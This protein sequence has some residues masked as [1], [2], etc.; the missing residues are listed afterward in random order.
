[1]TENSTVVGNDPGPPTPPAVVIDNWNDETYDDTSITH[2]TVAETTKTWLTRLVFPL[3]PRAPTAKLLTRINSLISQAALS[4]NT[5]IIPTDHAKDRFIVTGPF[6]NEQVLSNCFVHKTT[7]THIVG[8]LKIR[9]PV[10][11]SFTQW[12]RDNGSLLQHMQINKIYWTTTSLNSLDTR[13]PIFL[14]D[15]PSTGIDLQQLHHQITV[16]C[17]IECPFA[18][19]ASIV[20]E[21]PV[22][23]PC[24]V[25]ECD[26]TDVQKVTTKM[27]MGLIKPIC[28]KLW[29]SHPI[30]RAKPMT[31]SAGVPFYP[32]CTKICRLEALTRQRELMAK[33]I[34][35]AFINVANIDTPFDFNNEKLTLRDIIYD[36]L[37]VKGTRPVHGI[38]ETAQGRILISMDKTKATD[39]LAKL[40][41]LFT[42]M[43]QM[44]PLLQDITGYADRPRRPNDPTLV[45]P[46]ASAYIAKLTQ[47]A[48]TTIDKAT[49]NKPIRGSS[50]GMESSQQNGRPKHS[51]CW[52][53]PPPT[54]Y[55]MNAPHQ[56]GLPLQKSKAIPDLLLTPIDDSMMHIHDASITEENMHDAASIYDP[57]APTPPVLPQTTRDDQHSIIDVDDEETWNPSRGLSSIAIAAERNKLMEM[58]YKNKELSEPATPSACGLK[59]IIDQCKLMES[60]LL[61]Q[62]HDGIKAVGEDLHVNLHA[63]TA[64]KQDLSFLMTRQQELV[65]AQSQLSQSQSE[66]KQDMQRLLRGLTQITD[67]LSHGGVPSTLDI[68]P[69]VTSSINYLTTIVQEDKSNTTEKLESIATALSSMDTNHDDKIGSM[70]STL[71]RIG[72]NQD[73]LMSAITNMHAT[74]TSTLADMRHQ[75]NIT[76]TTSGDM[77]PLG[78]KQAVINSITDLHVMVHDDRRQTSEILTSITSQ[79]ALMNTN[80]QELLASIVSNQ[81]D[82]SNSMSS[83]LVQLRTNQ[84]DLTSAM[85]QMS[86]HISSAL[87]NMGNNLMIAANNTSTQQSQALCAFMQTITDDRKHS[88]DMITRANGSNEDIRAAIHH[89]STSTTTLVKTQQELLTITNNKTHGANCSSPLR[90]LQ[91]TPIRQTKKRAKS[92]HRHHTWTQQILNVVSVP[93][94]HQFT[95][96]TSPPRT[97]LGTSDLVTPPAFDIP[98]LQ[99]PPLPA[100]LPSPSPLQLEGP[101]MVVE[102]L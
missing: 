84:D 48:A 32:T 93:N 85:T 100:S 95:F 63:T 37:Q 78:D 56:Q 47:S 102:E 8:L 9:L 83:T 5:C 20:T 101:G 62:F 58:L 14:Y 60:D 92:A 82:L 40:E 75:M 39:T 36:K 53:S 77:D 70:S 19:R 3:A 99:L 67:T 91:S 51:N 57:Y 29:T 66:M 23:A 10:D 88:M 28:N 44:G 69:G 6:K 11:L 59:A 76:T 87:T 90:I 22:T 81:R 50:Q 7:R 42:T 97:T 46:Q 16:Q 4:K 27:F 24:I 2:N 26:A 41:L 25:V 31:L 13:T 33:Q 35:F 64:L 96:G 45:H 34:R 30:S 54:I 68:S 52:T 61:H 15:I 79:L 74:M 94:G 43:G 98:L 18:L 65:Q 72:L 55:S 80:Q 71:S 86:T 49:A 89:L 12:K 38:V 73:G 17:T 21:Q 1:M